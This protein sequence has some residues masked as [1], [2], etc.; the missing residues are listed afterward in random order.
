MALVVRVPVELVVL[1]PPP[2]EPGPWPRTGVET[3]V[4]AGAEL[5]GVD[6]GEAG[7]SDPC[8]P[9]ERCSAA[10]GETPGGDWEEDTRTN[11]FGPEATGLPPRA[12]DRPG[13][14]AVA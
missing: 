9:G 11:P 1:W 13:P 7:D 12:T 4:G 3:G 5:G 10:C 8:P 2:E 6:G 14:A